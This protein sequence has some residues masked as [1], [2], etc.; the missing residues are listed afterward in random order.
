MQKKR[1]WTV[2]LIVILLLSILACEKART[3]PFGYHRIGSIDKFLGDKTESL[4]HH[5][6][7]RKDQ[8]GLSAMSTM[9]SYDLD[10]LRKEDR[11]GKTIYVCDLCGS[12]F[13]EEGRVIAGPAEVNLPY[14]YLSVDAETVGAPKDT[15]YVKVGEEV[16]SEW[17]LR[18]HFVDE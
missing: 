1:I 8:V 13:S 7:I 10:Y 17:R 11:D 18:I 6:I 9:C 5:L 3:R 14:Y 2:F 12:R 4:E 16:S 15:L